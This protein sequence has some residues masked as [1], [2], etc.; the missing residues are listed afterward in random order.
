MLQILQFR[1]SLQE[2]PVALCVNRCMFVNA[3]ALFG[4]GRGYHGKQKTSKPST[5]EAESPA[6]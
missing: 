3:G 1:A 4:V 6:P 2:H 5:S